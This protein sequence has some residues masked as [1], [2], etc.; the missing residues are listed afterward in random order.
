VNRALRISVRLA[1]PVLVLVL[2]VGR[3]GAG[4]FL[5]GL[6]SVDLATLGL[7]VAIGVLTTVCC[8][9]RW[10]VVSAGLGVPLGLGAAVTAYYRSLFLNVAL[11]GGVV[12]D[13]H[14]GVSQGRDGSDVR[15]GLRAVMWERGAGQAVQL[16]MTA[17]VLTALP[18]PV[19]P[20]GPSARPRAGEPC[21]GARGD[22]QSDH[23]VG[24]LRAP[25]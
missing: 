25:R 10:R 1:V 4:P 16:V 22:E 21:D 8:A 23:D 17:V 12:G 5:D 24:H 13:V 9:W 19:R 20:P 3:V 14:R 6:G 7:A 2:L 15:R 18:S 11:P